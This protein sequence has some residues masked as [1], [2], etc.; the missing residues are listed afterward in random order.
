A[1]VATTAID[2]QS[3]DLGDMQRLVGSRVT[4]AGNL[5]V[6][7]CDSAGAE[8]LRLAYNNRLDT[9]LPLVPGEV[10]TLTVSAPVHRLVDADTRDVALYVDGAVLS[11]V[12]DAFDT[13]S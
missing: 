4:S 13:A 10:E 9:Q 12:S 5:H 1:S 7:M 2:D 6:F 3:V 11:V 8:C